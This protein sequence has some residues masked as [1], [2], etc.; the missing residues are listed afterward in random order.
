MNSTHF[1]TYSSLPLMH[2][3]HHNKPLHSRRGSSPMWLHN[4]FEHRI[5]SNGRTDNSVCG[6]KRTEEEQSLLRPPPGHNEDSPSWVQSRETAS[7]NFV[8]HWMFLVGCKK[9]EKYEGVD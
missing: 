7:G 9:D 3:F 1:L 5:L 4:T 2:I 8:F 6:A